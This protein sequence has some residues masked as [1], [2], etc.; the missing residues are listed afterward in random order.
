MGA[1]PDAFSTHLDAADPKLFVWPGKGVYATYNRKPHIKD[2]K[3]P[4]CDKFGFVQYMS[5]VSW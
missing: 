3:Q 2:P 4:L 1:R 5:T